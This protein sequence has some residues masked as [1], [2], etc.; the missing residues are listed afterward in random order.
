[1][2]IVS[3]VLLLYHSEDGKLE[4]NRRSLANVEAMLK[5][6]ATTSGN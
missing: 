5:S 3:V 6:D 4:S 2:I 1:V